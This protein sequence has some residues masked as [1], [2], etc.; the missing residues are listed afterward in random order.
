MPLYAT[1]AESDTLEIN[2][3]QYS[4]VQ[5][6]Y[7]EVLV[8]ALRMTKKIRFEKRMCDGRSEPVLTA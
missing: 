4:T 5:Y 6:Q 8:L 7:V 1:V 2:F 3:M